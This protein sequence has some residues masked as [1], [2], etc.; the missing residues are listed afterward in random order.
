LQVYWLLIFR[1]RGVGCRKANTTEN[2]GLLYPPIAINP[3]TLPKKTFKS[4]SSLPTSAASYLSETSRVDVHARVQ[5]FTDVAAPTHAPLGVASTVS[6]SSEDNAPGPTHSP[7]FEQ[8]HNIIRSGFGHSA[9]KECY[10]GRNYRVVR[11][12]RRSGCNEMRGWSK[13]GGQFG[14]ES[15]GWRRLC[16]RYYFLGYWTCYIVPYIVPFDARQSSKK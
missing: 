12:R 3:H 5:S 7:N 9:H 10:Q 4:T 15:W 8:T 1:S 6:A 11:N 13:R 2:P 16:C 14:R